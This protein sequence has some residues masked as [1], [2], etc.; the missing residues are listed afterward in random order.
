MLILGCAGGLE[1]AGRCGPAL[2]HDAIAVR[3]L[4]A[5]EEDAIDP[6]DGLSG[7]GDVA[8]DHLAVRVAPARDV[9]RIDEERIASPEAHDPQN[10]LE[11]HEEEHGHEERRDEE[12]RP[13]RLLSCSGLPHWMP[14]GRSRLTASCSIVP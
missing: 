4:L 12:E 5:L 11:T 1:E 7:G 3:R 2:D 14:L 13:S 6:R 10:E 9:G 8:P